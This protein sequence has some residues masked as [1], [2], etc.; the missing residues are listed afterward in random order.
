M[1]VWTVLDC[2]VPY[3]NALDVC[4]P[5]TAC[6]KIANTKL[7]HPHPPDVR[8]NLPLAQTSKAL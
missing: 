2:I 7:L 6:T 8:Y 5:V 4:V 1:I 3:C